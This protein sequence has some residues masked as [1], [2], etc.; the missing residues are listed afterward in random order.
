MEF[1][2]SD[3]VHWSLVTERHEGRWMGI[4]KGEKRAF[5]TLCLG[6]PRLE[7]AAGLAGE[8]HAGVLDPAKRQDL[9]DIRQA[10]GQLEL[11][12]D[13]VIVYMYCMVVVNH[14]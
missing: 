8:T 7:A 4:R 11:L 3:L 6:L 14:A 12:A 13:D 5:V 10:R 1:Q 9:A 2:G